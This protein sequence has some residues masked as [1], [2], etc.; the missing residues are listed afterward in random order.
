M[1]EQQEVKYGL[2]TLHTLTKGVSTVHGLNRANNG[3]TGKHLERVGQLDSGTM[4]YAVD[5]H[6]KKGGWVVSNQ[7]HL[8]EQTESIYYY[9]LEKGVDALT[10][11]NRLYNLEAS[12]V[13]YKYR[14]APE[15]CQHPDIQGL[16]LNCNNSK[17]LR[18]RARNNILSVPT[19]QIKL[20]TN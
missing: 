11:R 1:V 17:A 20:P 7:Q 19:Q 18:N 4:V 8:I 5:P 2:S 10:I 16:F 9:Y 13:A 6:S 12:A 14:M 15:E 3:Q